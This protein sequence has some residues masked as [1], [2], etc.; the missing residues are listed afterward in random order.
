[1]HDIFK[2][3]AFKG[4][5]YGLG[6]SLNGLV[7]FLLVPFF[8]QQLQATEYGR[9]ALAE[10]LLNLM[11][12]VLGMGI[13][14]GLLSQYNK[15]N[16]TER[17]T[18]VSSL[19]SV[20]IIFCSVITICVITLT[21]IYNSLYFNLSQEMI[22]LVVIIATL[23]TIWLL[24]A[25]LFRAEGLAWYYIIASFI[26]VGTGLIVTV[27]FILYLNYREE[28]ILYGR[29]IGNLLL[30]ITLS[31][32][33]W[34]YRPHFNIKP[35]FKVIKIGLPLVPA[36][37][38][39]MWIIMSPRF[40][41]EYFGN[42]ADVGIFS[43]SSKIANV[44]ILLFVKPFSMAWMVAI[45]KIYQHS[46]AKNIYSLVITYYILIA[47]ILALSLG[48][49][50]PQLVSFL[51]VK[52]SF[53]ISSHI[54]SIMTLAYV[55]SGLIYP[56]NIGPYVLNKTYKVLPVFA[57]SA[58]TATILGWWMAFFWGVT[59]ASITLVVVYTIQVIFLAK[60]SQKLYFIIFEWSRLIKLFLAFI[61]SFIVV[62]YFNILFASYFNSLIS[63]VMFITL[64]ILILLV[65]KFPNEREIF[66]IKS[67]TL[68]WNSNE[69]NNILHKIKIFK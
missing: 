35:A 7:S 56:I 37:F 15:S 51:V 30:L 64:V 23:E 12:I 1:M 31:P 17:S 19:F 6:S 66:L 39:S 45:F 4:F 18:L 34:Q 26:Q 63:F 38:A 36:T 20:V 13:N 68:K 58:I 25:T 60:I 50:T 48:I 67:F 9:F 41:I 5:I 65:L 69:K 61:C 40:F 62:Q 53:T 29:L 14:V 46:D 32:K 2:D 33:I 11:L 10:M 55:I 8:L 27:I 24:F 54:T 16:L 3:L 28:G 57:I 49:I 43:I 21:F 42:T 44:I 22:I 59:G 52:E 47:G